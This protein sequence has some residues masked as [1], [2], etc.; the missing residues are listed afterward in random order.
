M[1]ILGTDL[2][3]KICSKSMFLKLQRKRRNTFLKNMLK[4]LKLNHQGFNLQ[5]REF[6]QRKIEFSPPPGS[7]PL[8]KNQIV[9]D[10]EEEVSSQDRV[11]DCQKET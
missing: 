2:E 8:L 5:K 1:M 6:L 3:E 4:N 7:H 11:Q 10:L 9:Q